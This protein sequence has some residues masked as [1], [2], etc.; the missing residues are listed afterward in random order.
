MRSAPYGSWPSPVTVDMLTSEV[1]GLSAPAFDGDRLHWLEARA[2][3]GGRSSVWREGSSGAPEEVTPP[4]WNVRSR[5]NE[6]GGGEYAV[7]QG[8]VVFSDVRDGRLYRLSDGNEPQPITPALPLRYA[9][10]R[11]HSERDLVLAVR[12]DHRPAGEPVTT[13]VALG[14]TGD[15]ADGGR[16]LCTGADF[17]ASPALSGDGRLAWTEWNHPDMP[18]DATALMV[19]RFDGTRVADRYHVAGAPGVPRCTRPGRRTAA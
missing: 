3:Q 7:A 2:D 10:L 6:Y 18:W 5:V 8:V 17:Y 1:I 14:L 12:E 9:D 15:D 11:L 4:P 16:V 13:I 19:G